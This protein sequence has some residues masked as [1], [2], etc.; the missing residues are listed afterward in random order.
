[1]MAAETGVPESC[2]LLV[3]AGYVVP[4]VPHGVVLEDHAVAVRGGEIVALLPRAE[5]RARFAAAEVVSRPDGVVLPGFVNAHTHNPMTLMRGIADDLPL[6]TWLQQHIWPA[7]SQWM[8]EDF[9]RDGSALAALEMIRTGTTC[10]SD[11]YYFPEVSAE[12]ARESGLRAQINFPVLDFP[13]IWAQSADEY[14]HKGLSLHDDYRSVERITVGFGPHSAYTVSDAPL[15]RLAVLADEVQAPIHIHLHETA[16]EITDS[17]REHGVRPIDRLHSLGVITPQTQCVHMTQVA[18]SDIER[19]QTTGASVVHCP[20]SNLKLASGIC[21]VQT[22]LDADIR[23]ALGT[24]GA[25]S[26]NDLDMFGELA[27]AAL[28][29]K[30]AANNAAALNAHRVLEMATLGGAQVLCQDR[31]IGSL[32]PGKRADVIAVRIDD[33]NLLPRYDVASVLVY[34][35][36][37]IRV[38]HSW[39]DGKLL[40]DDTRVLSLNAADLANRARHWQR[41]LA[42]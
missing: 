1:M 38:T 28:I 4:V 42:P 35:N 11:T 41:K 32:E 37:H 7:E 31:C 20:E 24:D 16:T 25:A 17:L 5:A 40:M 12:V 33:V 9:V 29:G 36:R 27:T 18:A 23:V 30:H 6:K 21:P 2:D 19:L 10:F 22:L 34:N 3:E 8:S 13:S 14:I 39:V 15:K 26:N